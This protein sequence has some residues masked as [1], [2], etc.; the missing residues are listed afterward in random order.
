[1]SC[2]FFLPTERF[3]EGNWPHPQRLPL[4]EGWR[5]ICTASGRQNATPSDQQVQELCN[6]GYPAACE[7]F[8]KDRAADAVRFAVVRERGDK[9]D[10]CYVFEREHRPGEFGTLE[11]DVTGACAAPHPNECVQRMA[12]CF[13]ESY[14]RRRQP[15]QA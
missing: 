1:M 12:G 6:L 13:V 3:P 7:H 4:G 15:S 9:L 8:P 11:F 10:L 14:V 2:P 5:G